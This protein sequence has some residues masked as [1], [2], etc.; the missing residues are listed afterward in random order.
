MGGLNVMNDWEKE[1]GILMYV[2]DVKK[3]KR[4]NNGH[5]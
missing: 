5:R 1:L 3:E 4:K 2:M